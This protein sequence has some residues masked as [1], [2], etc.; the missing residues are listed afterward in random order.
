MNVYQDELTK[1]LLE[2]NHDLSYVQA[3]TWVELLWEDFES[4]YAKAGWEYKGSEMTERIVKQWIENYGDKLHE[5]I[6]TNPKYK[7][8]LNQEKGQTH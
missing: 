1:L 5:F 2:K 8:F 3:R 4:T 6:A 7:H